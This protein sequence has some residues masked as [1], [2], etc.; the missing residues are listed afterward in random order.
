MSRSERYVALPCVV[1]LAIAV[2]CG[3]PYLRTNPYD[4]DT[5]G[6]FE[7]VGPDSLFSAGEFAQ[8]GVQSTPT[9]PDTA[10]SWTVDSVA[11][12][13]SDTGSITVDGTMALLPSGA[14]GY[15]ATV[16]PLEPASI[17]VSV[18]AFVGA[19]DTTLARFIPN[20]PGCGCIVTFQTKQ[21]RRI[22]HKSVVLTQRVARIQSRCPDTHACDT[23][24]VGQAWSVWID[25]FD[26]LGNQIAARTY[27]PAAGAPVATFLSRDTTIASV[28]PV[29][30]RAASATA[31]KPGTTWI[32]ATH[33]SLHDSLQV[34][35]R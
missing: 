24:A 35:V 4:P 7:I 27:N 23:L 33:G 12:F 5:P 15:V 32:V 29:G 2:G 31:Q 28:V 34:V 6:N 14:G 19:V 21:Y 18:V 25:G 16:P 26:A 9:L 22:L 30:I 1:L 20:P 13:N 10:F 8:Y 11:T 17:T 3:D